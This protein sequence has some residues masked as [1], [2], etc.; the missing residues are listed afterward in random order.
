MKYI[1]LTG[2][3]TGKTVVINID[4]IAYISSTTFKDQDTT[5]VGVIGSEYNDISVKETV[6]EIIEKIE[7]ASNVNL[8]T[9]SRIRADNNPFFIKNPEF[10]CEEPK[11]R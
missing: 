10:T 8:T 4:A 7:A 9:P 5:I 6:D 3:Q 1:K 2:T 11:F